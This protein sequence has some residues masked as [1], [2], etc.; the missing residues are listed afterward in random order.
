VAGQCLKRAPL[1]KRLRL[2]GVR[3]GALLKTEEAAH[4][5]QKAP[6]APV[7][8]ALTAINAGA[9]NGELF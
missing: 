5:M 8:P 7:E 6:L 2:L 9:V 1:H 3:V 4:L